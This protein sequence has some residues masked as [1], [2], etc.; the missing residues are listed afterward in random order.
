MGECR[1]C[2][3]CCRAI[4]LNAPM[5]EFRQ[6]V[7]EGIACPDVLFIYNNW[8]PISPAEAYSVNPVLELWP[9]SDKAFYYRCLRIDQNNL[10]SVYKNR[11]YVCRGFPYYGW[12]PKER[13][14][15]P[16]VYYLYTDDCG[17]VED[18]K[19]LGVP[20]NRRSD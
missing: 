20:I 7:K 16:E 19:E 1:Q 3:S 5:D 4:F 18:W 11:P 12:L 8:V 2:G 14:V 15:L 13:K 6:Q 17:F 9:G 10:C